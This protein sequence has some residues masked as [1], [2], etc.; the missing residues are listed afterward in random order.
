MTSKGNVKILLVVPATLQLHIKIELYGI[1]FA[2]YLP[3]S[4]EMD[5]HI[6][7]HFTYNEQY[8][9]FY[10]FEKLISKILQGNYNDIRYVL[11]IIYLL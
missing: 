1:N 10:I 9:D 3:A 5:S 7:L 2:L 4:N 11:T 6:I 8:L